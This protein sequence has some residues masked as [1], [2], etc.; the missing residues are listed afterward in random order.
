MSSWWR[1][2]VVYQIYP[3][4][5]ADSDGD[6]VGDL[7]GITAHV[8][9]LRRLGVDAV[10]MS[11][12]YPSPGADGGYDVSDYMDIDPAYGTM[13]DFDTLLSTLHAA[14]IRLIVDVVPNHCSTAHPLFRRALAAGRGSAE[15]DLFH[16][17]DGTGRDGAEPPN[18]WQSHFGGPAWT[19]IDDGQWYLHLFDTTQP[20]F[21]WDNPAVHEYLQSVLR[22]WLDKGVDGFRVDVAHLLKKDPDLP[23]WGGPANGAQHPDFPTEDSPMFG[24]PEVHS[25]FRDW[26]VILDGYSQ[27]TGQERMMCGEVCVE[28][29]EWQAEWTRPSQMQMVFNFSLLTIPFTATAWKQAIRRS[30]SAYGTYAAPTT[31]VLSNHDVVRH[32]TRLGYRDGY[33]KPGDGIGPDDPQPDAAEGVERALAATALLLALPGSMY[34]YQGEELGLPDHTALAP[35]DRQD[36]TFHR[37][38][39]ARIGRDGCRVPLPWDDTQPGMGFGPSTE[40]WLPQPQGYAALSV[41]RQAGDPTSPLARYQDML[42]LRRRHRLGSGQWQMLEAEAELLAFDNDGIRVIMNPGDGAVDASTL[43]QSRS[44]A[45]ESRGGSLVDGVLAPRSTVW[46][47]Q[48]S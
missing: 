48:S 3:R 10:W 31:W 13:E 28:P 7:A 35:E 2:A 22:F 12:F 25:V 14:D 20:D 38:D 18:N 24:R 27:S 41:R 34:L 1:D 17:R 36:P 45:F 32:A 26:R 8:D 9:H 40:T 11:P 4:S 43:V 44:L 6:G 21:N 16:F 30:L 19:R 46:L 15:R 39:G 47:N 5:F 33:P 23:D 37:T 29:L 42:S